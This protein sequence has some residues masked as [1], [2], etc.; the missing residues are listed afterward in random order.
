ME[1]N[2]IISQI[3]SLQE[4]FFIMELNN[5]NKLDLIEEEI[6]KVF[7]EKQYEIDAN[8][9]HLKPIENAQT[10]SIDQIR[11][12][13]KE[14][15]H[16]NVLNLKRVIFISEINLLN[17]NSYNSLLKVI[18]EIPKDTYFIFCTSN[19]IK[20]PETIISRAK[21]LRDQEIFENEDLQSYMNHL[22][23]INQN[24]SED[25]IKDL[26]EPF[27][28]SKQSDFFERVKLFS[29]DQ[30][31]LC[32]TIFIKILSH[33]LRLNI[34]NNKLFKYLIKL[35]SDFIYDVDESLKF[36]TLTNDLISIY[37]T[38][39]NSNLLKYGN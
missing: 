36:N 32:S 4:G 39:L 12:L 22:I 8:F 13:K 15:L 30:I 9:T 3:Y 5:S 26:F 11:T 16:T 10:I 2:K 29:K 20:V 19:I 35:H 31:H 37:F 14:F 21:V 17:I 25:I 27:M 33:Y 6:K 34:D 23:D 18:E 7:F 38:R 1:I 28:Q 24:I